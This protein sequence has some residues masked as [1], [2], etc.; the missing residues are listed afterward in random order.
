MV[1]TENM[2]T[3]SMSSPPTFTRA[4][5]EIINVSYIVFRFFYYLNSLNILKIL[6]DLRIVVDEAML[7]LVISSR[8][9]PTIEPTETIKSK[10]FHS[11]LKYLLP[12]PVTLIMTSR[13]KIKV[14][15]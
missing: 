12:K 1:R 6:K 9:I 11:S 5:K 10:I 7:T 15:M 3:R 8:I 2:K 13:A 4:G 14:H